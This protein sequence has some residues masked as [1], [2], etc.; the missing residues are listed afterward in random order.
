MKKY[1]LL[2]IGGNKYRLEIDD[3]LAKNL[4]RTL[5]SRYT[6]DNNN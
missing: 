2:A 1:I 3:S 5:K 6:F 4:K